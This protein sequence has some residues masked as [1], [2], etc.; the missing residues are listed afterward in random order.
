LLGVEFGQLPSNLYESFLVFFDISGRAAFDSYGF[1]DSRGRYHLNR[2][3][4][5]PPFAKS[6]ANT[7][8]QVNIHEGLQRRKVFAGYLVNAINGTNLDT[9]LAASAIVCE[10][11]GQFFR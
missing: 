9:G 3:P 2:V 10:D 11:D 7:P 8:F 4:G 6:A 1:V 5:A